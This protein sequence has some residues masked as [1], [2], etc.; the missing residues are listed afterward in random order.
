VLADWS[1]RLGQDLF[2]PPNVGGWPGG[3]SW[4]SARSLIGRARYA[5]A[6]V[7]AQGIGRERP[8][9]PIALARTH[10]RGS[11]RGETLTF[12][13]Q[14]LLGIKPEDGWIERLE[15]A[16][17]GSERWNEELARRAVV[18]ILASPEGQVG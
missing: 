10:G 14:V 16:I 11:S 12:L 9:E 2:D 18:Q 7:D 13:R 5:S 4:L 6:L 3:R 8:L 17:G 15:Q 1:T